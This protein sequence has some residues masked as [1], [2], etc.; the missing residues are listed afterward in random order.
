MH[1]AAASYAQG[2]SLRCTGLQTGARRAA[3]WGIEARGCL[4]GGALREVVAVADGLLDVGPRDGG[5]R[6]AL[7]VV[8][9]RGAEVRDGARRDDESRQTEHPEDLGHEVGV[10]ADTVRQLGPRQSGH[11]ELAGHLVQSSGVQCSAVG[12]GA[13]Q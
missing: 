11:D 6:A 2:C 4:I 13:V 7:A 12:W 5:A 9:E 1:R 8:A 10:V 3:A